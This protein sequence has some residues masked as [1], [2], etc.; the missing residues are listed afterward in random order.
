MPDYYLSLISRCVTSSSRRCQNYVKCGWRGSRIE[1][2]SRVTV[3]NNVKIT[4]NHTV[5]TTNVYTSYCSMNASP[6][7]Y[8]IGP[9]TFYGIHKWCKAWEGVQHHKSEILKIYACWE[10]PDDILVIWYRY[11]DCWE[12]IGESPSSFNHFLNIHRSY[13][14][15][16][17]ESKQLRTGSGSQLLNQ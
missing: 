14:A 9:H 4:R 1:R 11:P 2:V 8:L 5:M 16:I 3:I 17:E 6:T 13:C 12:R 15:N 7:R 10:Y